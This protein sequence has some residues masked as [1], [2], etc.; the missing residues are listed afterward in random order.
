MKNILLIGDQPA[1]G[2]NIRD[3]L[4]LSNFKVL[5]AQDTVEAGALALKERPDLL[6]C[7]LAGPGADLQATL[8]SIQHEP[9]LRRLPLIVF[10]G[11]ADKANTRRIMDL[12]ADDYL[13]KP[14]EGIELL[15]AVDACLEKQQRRLQAPQMAAGS[16]DPVPP[17]DAGPWRP[18]DRDLQ[19]YRKKKMLYAEGHRASQVWYIAE[20]KI[21]TFLVH[22]DGKELITG[23]HGPGECVGYTA[24]LGRGAHTDNAQVL[25]DAQLI[26]ISRQEFLSILQSDSALARQL[27]HWLAKSSGETDAG[28]LNLAYSSLRKKVANGILRLAANL[29][30]QIEGK[31]YITVSRENLA[32]FV[33][34][35]PESLTRTL[36]DFRKEGLIDITDGRIWL[37]NEEKLR[38]MLN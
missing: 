23:I 3:I 18:A 13:V 34:S 19:Y 22:P 17:V 32:A 16:H 11:D 14:F 8:A 30:Q 37:L 5:T 2:N 24:V 33:G 12:G 28:M 21:K 26:G 9:T 31:R 36:G 7:D 38:K 15:R 10:T 27:V 29:Q 35:A 25:E 4:A 20:G 1:A 6:I